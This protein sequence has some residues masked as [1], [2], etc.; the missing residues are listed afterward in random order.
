MSETVKRKAKAWGDFF[1]N[2]AFYFNPEQLIGP[3][4]K[5]FTIG[6]CFAME[7]RRAIIRRGIQVVPDYESVK[8]DPMIQYY[9]SI[10]IKREFTP[11]YDTFVMRQEFETALGLWPNRN[12]GFIT[13]KASKNGISLEWDEIHQDPYRKHVFAQSSEALESLASN[14]NHT[15]RDGLEQADVI[16]MTLGLTE[17]WQSV[18]TGKYFC[19]APREQGQAQFHASKFV[20]NYNNVK[21]ILEMVGHH[22]P[23][24]RF[25]LSVSPVPLG[26]SVRQMDIFSAN[27]ESKSILRAV[28]GQICEEFPSVKYFPSYEVATSQLWPVF[29]EDRRHILPEF[30]DL[31]VS[32]FM[33]VYAAS[34]LPKTQSPAAS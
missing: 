33:D 9:D 16:V 22:Y 3:T 21:A 8:Y 32:G 14:I 34:A 7:V 23:Q 30:A 20:E 11:H 15:F 5:V 24:K 26:Q 12:E 13:L 10:G 28:A 4:S 2:P 25:I 27:L 19:Q 17:V 1:K 31:V 29:Q 6:S 18:K